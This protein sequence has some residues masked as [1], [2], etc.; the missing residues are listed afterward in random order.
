MEGPDLSLVVLQSRDTPGTVAQATFLPF[1]I[2]LTYLMS[3]ETLRELFMNVFSLGLHQIG[4]MEP[5]H[6]D[7]LGTSTTCSLVMCPYFRGDTKVS[8]SG[9]A[10]YL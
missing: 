7:M 4:N 3:R 6:V 1:L 5:L 2:Q 8:T 9:S 10:I